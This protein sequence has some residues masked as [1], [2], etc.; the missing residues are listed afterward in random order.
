[1][2]LGISSRAE[3]VWVRCSVLYGL[4]VKCLLDKLSQPELTEQRKV[5]KSNKQ[6][7]KQMQCSG[8]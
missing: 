6:T 1:M 8:K 7:K 4:T 3:R 2:D 5:R